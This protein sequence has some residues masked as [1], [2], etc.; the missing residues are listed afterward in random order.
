MADVFISSI[1]AGFEDVRAAARA[2]VETYGH[3]AVMAE[4][5]GAAAT[6][7]QRALLDRVSSSDVLLL[8][9]GPR[10]G[11]RQAS[12]LS[13]T[14]EEFDEARRRGKPILVLV[15]EGERESEQ[16]EF[17]ARTTGGWEGG[18]FRDTFRDGSNVG[19]AVVRALR[20]LDERGARA[21]LEPAAAARAQD[22][23][24]GSGREGYGHGGS[25]AR[26]VLVP[27]LGHR[28]LDARRL[29]DRELPDEIAGAARAARLVPQSA[30]I[31]SHVSADG[32]RLDVGERHSGLTL[33]VGANGEIVAEA[34]VSGDDQN[35]GSMRIIP[36]RL[37][38]AIRGAMRFAESVWQRIDPRGEVQ[39]LAVTIAIPN[40]QQKSWG[41]GRGGNSISMGGMFS[42]PQTAISPQPPHIVRRADLV[43]DETTEDLVAEMRRV[44]VDGGAVDER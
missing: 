27:L 34:S 29:E 18:I 19:L 36:E 17:L 22:L 2:G 15:Q 41:P 43:R 11:V 42:M 39:E 38:E 31:T 25:N 3:R 32:I 13:A 4:T 26:I 24:T 37:Q 10:Y 23:A 20:N 44:F 12:G 28:L 30:G 1:Q 14:E 9:V 40:A 6:S 7:P 35:F 33:V 8:L 16:E 5:S 21:E